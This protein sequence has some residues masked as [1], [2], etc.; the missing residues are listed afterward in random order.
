MFRYKLRTLLI[1]LAVGPPLLWG[2]FS[3]WQR[4]AQPAV[5]INVPA[6][7]PA[8]LA[9]DFAFPVA[10]QDSPETEAIKR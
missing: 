3:L 7:G 5:V 1:L 8:P 6:M 2:V 9:F 10:S 4:F